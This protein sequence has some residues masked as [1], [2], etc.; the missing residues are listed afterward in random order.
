MN[1][2]EEIYQ[3]LGSLYQ[4]YIS[5]NNGEYP[6]ALYIKHDILTALLKSNQN[7]VE[8]NKP[9]LGRPW[10]KGVLIYVVRREDTTFKYGFYDQ[11]YVEIKRGNPNFRVTKLDIS[12]VE[13]DDFNYE[14]PSPVAK[15]LDIPDAVLN[16][17]PILEYN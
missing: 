5:D 17:S 2:I 11:E 1:N 4:T 9:T 6:T 14:Y 15:V 3:E 12:T 8:V 10:Y 7:P 13:F 16:P